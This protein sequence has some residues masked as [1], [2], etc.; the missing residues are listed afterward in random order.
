MSI[1]EKSPAKKQLPKNLKKEDPKKKPEMSRAAEE[2]LRRDVEE[3]YESGYLHE[4]L[5]MTQEEI[6]QVQ[7]IGMLG[8]RGS[9]LGFDDGKLTSINGANIQE[10]ARKSIT[11]GDMERI[12]PGAVEAIGTKITVDESIL[13]G[14]GKDETL[15]LSKFFN[16]IPYGIINKNRTGVGA[17]TLEINAKRNSI[18]VMP[19][20]NLAFSKATDGAYVTKTGAYKCCYV[21][22]RIDQYTRHKRLELDAYLKYPE[23]EYKKFIVVADSLCKVIEAIGPQVYNKYFLMLDEIDSYQ[24]DST[25]RKSMANTLDFYFEFDQ[26]MRCMVTA[27]MQKFSNPELSNEPVVEIEYTNP[28]KRDVTLIHTNNPNALVKEKIERIFDSTQD[29]IVIA[30]NKVQ[31]IMEVIEN[32]GERYKKECAV[33]CSEM[34]KP[35]VKDYYSKRLDDNNKLPKRINFITC[36]YFTGIDIEERFHLLSVANVEFYFSL[37]SPDKLMQIAGRGRRG[38]LSE[39]II[40]NAKKHTDSIGKKVNGAEQLRD[41]SQAVIDYINAAETITKKFKDLADKS[42]LRVQKEIENRSKV[43][44]YKWNKIDVVRRNVFTGKYEIAYFNIAA[45]HEAQVLRS[46]LYSSP[47][48]L[49][50]ELKNSVNILNNKYHQENRDYTPEQ[51][52]NDDNVNKRFKKIEENNLEQLFKELSKKNESLTLND[53]TLMKIRKEEVRKNQLIVDQFSKLY[54]YVPFD[55]LQTDLTDIGG[56]AKKFRG[57]CN[58]VAFWALAED[59]IF[60]MDMKARFKEGEKYTKEQIKEKIDAVYMQHFDKQID[61]DIHV[62]ILGEYFLTHKNPHEKL[63]TVKSYN[64]FGFDFEPLEI[65]SAN[66]NL[67][68]LDLIGFS[69]GGSKSKKEAQTSADEDLLNLLRKAKQA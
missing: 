8:V 38:L 61:S 45:L 51:R 64:K 27:T 14:D 20:K 47:E 6:D 58:A 7:P 15:Y 33:L 19:T 25:F 46:K 62:Q 63:H 12:L 43:Q 1:Q 22:S 54:K 35:Y 3:M 52:T 65:I 30:Y 13:M 4:I 50:E 49:F 9:I 24:S 26:H 16:K 28:K 69:N 66:Q 44:Y 40:Y 32:L 5:S 42:F 48:Q 39:Q 60:K 41:Y 68:E 31:Y 57:Y 59:H 37:L 36:T 17:T 56:H 10:E 23:I 18:I 11:Y 21:G 55:R 2:E 29:K 53:A 67:R 34:S